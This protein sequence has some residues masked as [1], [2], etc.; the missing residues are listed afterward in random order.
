[1]AR[2]IG[3]WRKFLALGAADENLG[4]MRRHE[5]TGRP[6]G[7]QTF[8]ENMEKMLGRDLTRR[9]PGPKPRAPQR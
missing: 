2:E 4:I 9:K 6:L 8:V 3:S 5:R 1:M 7:S